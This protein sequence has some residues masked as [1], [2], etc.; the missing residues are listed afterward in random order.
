MHRLRFEDTLLVVYELPL[1]M[2]KVSIDDVTSPKPRHVLNRPVLLQPRG[3][4]F[5]GKSALSGS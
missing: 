1:Q 3:A 4:G 2:E 5:A